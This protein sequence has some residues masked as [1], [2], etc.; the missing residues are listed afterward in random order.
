MDK[1]AV[2]KEYFGHTSF[3]EGQGEI[4]DA[5]LSGRD[6]LGIMPTS[7]GKSICFQIP[8]L[9]LHGTAVVV[10]PL[11][12]LMKDQVGA[13]SQAGISAAF[14][15]SSLSP[16]EYDF[17]LDN[18][19]LGAYK[20]LY[21]APER[22]CTPSFLK[23]AE[24]AELSLIAVDEAHCVSQW[25]QDFRPSYTRIPEFTSHLKT[26]PPIAAFTATATAEVR[27]DISAMLGLRSPYKIVTGFDRKNLFFSVVH[28]TD[29]NKLSELE[30]VINRN[31]GRSG[32]IYCSTRKAVEE[33]CSKL[34]EKGYPCGRYHAGLDDIERRTSQDDFVYDKIKYIV[35]TN[36]F[37]MGIDK[38]NVGF[39]VH[40]NCPKDIE[41]YY[42]EAG[43][44]GRDGE[45]AECVLLYCPKD[46]RTQEFL[47]DSSNENPDLDDET[48]ALIRQRDHERL[49]K[50]AYYCTTTDCLREFILHYFG[51][52]TPQYCGK[53]SNC[54]G[55]FEDRDVT[56]DAQK[57]LSCVYRAREAYMPVAEGTIVD[58]LHGSKAEKII[59][60]HLDKISTYNIMADV[61]TKR[62]KQITDRLIEDGYIRTD[63]E[64]KVLVLTQKAK[65][66]LSGGKKYVMKFPKESEKKPTRSRVGNDS[67]YEL[68]KALFG[69]LKTLRFKLAEQA[70]MPAYIIFTDSTLRDICI[71]RPTTIDALLECSGIGRRKAES[72][73]KQVTDIV[74]E[75][76]SK[77]RE[78][79]VSEISS[80]FDKAN[81]GNMLFKLIRFNKR[82]L[83][84]SGDP[85]SL[86]GFCDMMLEQLGI[87]ADKTVI[88]KSLESWLLKNNYLAHGA[89]G[90][91][92]VTT[93][94]SEEA[95]IVEIS[96][97]SQRG[98]EYTSLV[99]IP[100][101]Q[102]F[103]IDNI[104]DIFA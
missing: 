25:G 12:S 18:A 26:R 40:Y 64:Y 67:I 70:H 41:S 87:A 2:L 92:Y 7:A 76:V 83:S 91:K 69:K 84:A 16:Q 89:N 63:G 61:P 20:L 37:G 59:S 65:D 38:S 77:N 39:V 58:I 1:L 82:K 66:I 52:T 81:G 27:N 97:I 98:Q 85:V 42:Q 90:K 78:N 86:S 13:L 34:R 32:I 50:M 33:V 103:I 8:A 11:I 36:A 22:L 71:K 79:N 88:R 60:R 23:F 6:V 4:I 73:G 47:I 99:I 44:A 93:I 35:A 31:E 80:D 24:N 101:G 96:N 51:E 46:I 104:D 54:T 15:N 74:K 53:C 57:I 30:D 75:Y 29:K 17:V 3:R 45:N 21:V 56:V 10:S 55:G 95:G 49:R 68:D 28:A 19:S 43:R 100:D 102:Q 14:L 94:L 9:M 62:I 48:L 72:Y 5:L